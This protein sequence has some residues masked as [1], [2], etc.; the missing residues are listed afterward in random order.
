MA[1]YVACYTGGGVKGAAAHID[2]SGI[3][4][5][6][7]WGIRFQG[8]RRVVMQDI[9]LEGAHLRDGAEEDGVGVIQVKA[10]AMDAV[11]ATVLADRPIR[12]SGH[13]RRCIC[14]RRRR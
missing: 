14:G 7:S 9:R 5:V 4:V 11:C 8:N 10:R 1:K 12:G 2:T 6:H 13:R 3:T